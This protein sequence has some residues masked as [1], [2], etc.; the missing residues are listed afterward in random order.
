MDFEDVKEINL[1][2]TPIQNELRDLEL[3]TA[4]G[5]KGG[6]IFINLNLK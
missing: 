2:L 5:F 1:H 3:V 4:V 6:E